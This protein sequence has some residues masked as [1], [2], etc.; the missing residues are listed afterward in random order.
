M[1]L[2]IHTRRARC[3]VAAISAIAVA[4]SG[5]G[6]AHAATSRAKSEPTGN[7]HAVHTPATAPAAG[8]SQ[9]QAETQAQAQAKK[10]GKSVPVANTET[11][12]STLNANPNGTYTLTSAA[13]PVRALVNG[14]WQNLNATLKKNPDGT[15]SPILSSEPLSISGGGSAPL[16]KMRAGHD[17]LALTLP[18]TLPTPTLAGATATYH[19]VIPGVD[20]VVTVTSQGSF[21]DVYVVNTPAAAANPKLTDLLT[22]ST[23]TS[24]VSLHTDTVGDIAAVDTQ[25]RDVFTATAPSWWNSA[26]TQSAAASTASPSAVTGLATAKTPTRSSVAA[27]GTRAHVGRLQARISG[28]TL[29]LKPDQAL[30]SMPANAFPLYADPTWQ[31]A[32]GALTNQGWSTVSENYPIDTH[33]DSSPEQVGAGLMQVGESSAGF[34]AD[35]LVN[36]GLPLSELGAEGTTVKITGATF[37]ITAVGGDACVAQTDDLYA[38][39]QT[40]VGGSGT[41]AT[42]N[43][44]FTASRDLGTAISSASFDHRAGD[45]SCNSGG[46]GFHMTTSSQLSWISSDVAANK[47]VQ[48]LALAGA[49]YTAEE[50]TGHGAGQNDYA[51]F[52]QNTPVLS[53]SFEHSPAVPDRLSINPNETTVGKGSVTLNAH[54]Y[55]PDGGTL[56]ATFNAYANGNTADPIDSGTVAVGND[57][58]NY[59][60]IPESTL[61]N[62]ITAWGQAP[63]N[64]SMTVDWQVTVADS[65]GM[66]AQTSVQHFVYSTAVPGKPDIWTNSGDTL[67]CGGGSYTVGQPY[68]FY[69]SEPPDNGGAQPTNYTYQLNGEAGQ[70]TKATAGKASITIIPNSNTDVITVDGIATSTNVGQPA[71]CT[72]NATDPADAA[73]G[74]MT[75]NGNVSLLLPGNGSAALPSGLWLAAGQSDGTVAHDAINIGQNGTGFGNSKADTSPSTFDGT[76]VVSGLFQGAGYNDVLVYQ[77]S[78]SACAADVINDDGQTTPLDPYW[79]TPALTAGVLE[80]N[81][82][83]TNEVTCA[84]SIAGGGNLNAA[85]G[86]EGQ[87]TQSAP[88]TAYAPAYEPDLLTIMTGDLYLV[89]ATG[90]DAGYG[91]YDPINQLST[92]NPYCVANPSKSACAG[93]GSTWAGWQLTS[94]NTPSDIPALFAYNTSLNVVYYYS[95]ATLAGLVFDTWVTDD[96][97]DTPLA[98]DT[99]V[100]LTGIAPS[101]YLNLQ[102]TMLD[103]TPG[104]YATA[105]SGV[106][107]GSEVPALSQPA[108]AGFGTATTSVAYVTTFTL[109]GISLTSTGTTTLNTATH[110]YPLNDALSGA[111]FTTA[112]DDTGS[113]PLTAHGT[114]TGNTEDPV[115]NQDASFDGKTGYLTSTGSTGAINPDDDFTINAW[116]KPTAL[117]G[118]VA[119]QGGADDPELELAATAQGTWA[120]SLNT[121][122]TG[123]GNTYTTISGGQVNLGLWTQLTATY[124][125]ATGVATLYADGNEIAVGTDTSPPTGTSGAFTLG[126]AQTGTGSTYTSYF[127]GYMANVETYDAVATPTIVDAGASEYV[128][129]TPTRIIDTRSTSLIGSVTGPVAADST[130]AIQIAGNTTSGIDIPTA[131]VTAVAISLTEVDSTSNGFLTAYPDQTPQPLTSTVNYGISAAVTN[132]AIVPVGADG[133]IDIYNSSSGTAQFLIDVTGYYTT[134]TNT[135]NASTY[136]PLATPTRILDTRNAIGAPKAQIAAGSALTLQIAGN[137]TGGADI[138]ATGVTAVAV[139]L[140]A[141]DSTAGGQLIVYPDGATLPKTSNLNYV[142]G[143]G[144]ASTVVVPVGADGKIDI[145]NQSDASAVDVLADVSGYYTTAITGQYYFPTGSDRILD[146]RSYNPQN[147][148][149][150]PLTAGETFTL[151]IPA[152]ALAANPTLVLNL[153]VTDPTSNGDL[154]VYPGNQTTAP[155]ASAVNWAVNQTVANLNIAAS[156]AGDGVNITDQGTTGTVQLIIDTDGYFAYAT[157]EGQQ[158]TL[159]HNWP[160]TEGTGSAAEDTVGANPLSFTTSPTWT[161]STVGAQTSPSNVID[162]DGATQYGQTTTSALKTGESFTVA[163]WAN[164]D[165]TP[166]STAAIVA[167]S[168]SNAS[169]FYLEYNINENSW[170]M[171]FMASDAENTPGAP[172]I[173]CATAAPTTGTWYHLIGTYNA[174]TNT[175]ALYVNGQLASTATGVTDW[176]SNGALTVGAAQYDGGTTDYFPGKISNVQTY[177]YALNATQAAQLYQQDN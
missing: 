7:G 139:N 162:L 35:S 115:F 38:P 137:T 169:A 54:F 22:A 50:F 93:S 116:V 98:A 47:R 130:T 147:G 44:W 81:Q 69:L 33:Y 32:G 84:T 79:S 17:S 45:T 87:V 123:A 3:A 95:P 134:N 177:N 141:V 60:Y 10:T 132:N 144:L 28:K 104:L 142:S 90:T 114:V 91:A 152:T 135:G 77:P 94:I 16:A 111:S 36:F 83:D 88:E 82:S 9:A 165:A 126:A 37:Y 56:Q 155:T 12:T 131:A 176:P 41:N 145:Y 11:A 156:A 68:T 85:E 96:A 166:T 67:Q 127:D 117:G 105:T 29:S 30:S 103:G 100:A 160:L 146:T 154:D 40:L 72:I 21:S 59:L 18:V 49:S 92:E 42:W 53:I 102:A 118:V 51:V 65:G 109:N 121:S 71:S 119:S 108:L 23:A 168:G 43:D 120:M 171:N 27:P 57:T 76:E 24:G 170:C 124:N 140:T 106:G 113:L 2:F 133:K 101:D 138:P 153:T 78:S 167:Q 1:S 31:G 5:A 74:D 20:L 34:W 8:V 48:T 151:P 164:L 52:D 143:E 62:D 73:P 14:T 75:G 39:S 63:S 26:I 172:S 46:V 173:P 125:N 110:N 86:D 150:N 128:P 15:L 99:P 6:S 89:P 80:T 13:Q 19:N 122:A 158:A 174:A 175:T 149:A 148:K 159:T 58:F 112:A 4:L 161:T 66:T 61:N 97:A 70:S 136:V 64:T 55:D 107:S 163:A 157:P 129:L 25:G